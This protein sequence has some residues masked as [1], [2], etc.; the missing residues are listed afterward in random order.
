MNRRFEPGFALDGFAIITAG[1][2][3]RN[4][5]WLGAPGNCT[6]R[7]TDYKGR[8]FGRMPRQAP[9]WIILASDSG[10]ATSF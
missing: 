4:S 2:S 8:E 7:L 3:R 6:A 10:R 5:F 9:V 1:N